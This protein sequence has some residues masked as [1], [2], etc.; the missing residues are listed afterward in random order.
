MVLSFDPTCPINAARALRD[1]ELS[2]PVPPEQRAFFPMFPKN[3]ANTSWTGNDLY[4]VTKS[5]VAKV[6]P[7]NRVA[8]YSFHSFRIYL[9]CA[10]MADGKTQSEIQAFLRW[11]SVESVPVYARMNENDYEAAIQS[12]L[13]KEINSRQATTLPDIGDESFDAVLMDEA[14]R[15]A[16]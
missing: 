7:S 2:F 16:E 9:A 15:E 4:R 8:N 13:R 3:N 10:L 14:L 6:V 12:A 11:K 5:L 1:L